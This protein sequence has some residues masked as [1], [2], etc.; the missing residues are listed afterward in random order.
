MPRST[1]Y[2][3]P[4]L[5]V[6]SSQHDLDGIEVSEL[7]WADGRAGSL[8]LLARSSKRSEFLATMLH[9]CWH[10]AESRTNDD[11]IK[12]FDSSISRYAEQKSGH[13]YFISPLERHARLY[14]NFACISLEGLGPIIK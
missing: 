1:L 14:Q 9:K 10:I 13:S 7:A 4:K 3:G 2:L 5:L 11:V 8:I 12:G 6:S